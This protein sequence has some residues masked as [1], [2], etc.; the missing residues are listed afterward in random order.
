MYRSG[1]AIIGNVMGYADVGVRYS[2][3]F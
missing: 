2:D 1:T 3:F